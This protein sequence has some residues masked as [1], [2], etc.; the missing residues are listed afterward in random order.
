MHR[1]SMNRSLLLVV[2]VAFLLMMVGGMAWSAPIPSQTTS[3][4]TATPDAATVAAE[5]ELVKGQ[6]VA[7][8]LTEDEATARVALLTDGEV[9]A[10]VA[11]LNSIQPGG[12]TRAWTT[13]ELLLVIIIV[14]LVVS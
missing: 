4:A 13:E 11:D 14:I 7:Y 12:A 8:G 5:R 1:L 6:L 3:S 10:L 2:L 9:H